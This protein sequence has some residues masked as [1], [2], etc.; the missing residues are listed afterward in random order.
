MD[1]HILAYSAIQANRVLSALPLQQERRLTRSACKGK[2]A[3]QPVSD[4]VTVEVDGD[5]IVGF[6]SQSASASPPATENLS[7]LSIAAS[8]QALEYDIDTSGEEAEESLAH[9]LAMS[10]PF[11]PGPVSELM[12]E[13][14]RLPFTGRPGWPPRNAMAGESTAFIKLAG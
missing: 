12:K 13:H 7:L 6:V 2:V 14:D 8:P 10:E 4:Q 1:S 3:N 9:E 11:R 5:K